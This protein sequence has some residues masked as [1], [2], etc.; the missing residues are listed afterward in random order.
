MAKTEQK[1]E[2][3]AHK[4]SHKSLKKSL[5]P[6]IMFIGVALV[7]AVG[8]IAGTYNNQIM[9]ALGP[10]F[11][12]HAHA[13]E[14]DLSSVQ[15]TYRALAAN[16][17]GK[18]D[19]MAL[20]QGANHGLVAA[21]GDQYTV[22]MSPEEATA[23]D[24]G[25]AGNIGGGIGAEIG[26]RNDQVTIIRTLSGNPAE[27][28]GL[29]AGDIILKINDES[30]SGWTVEKAVG[31]IRGE[32]GT[33]VKLTIERGSDIHDYTI[34]RAIITNPSV[35]SSVSGKVGTLTI[36]RFDNETGTL[37]RA[38]AQS[39]VKQG[40]KDVILDLRGNGGGYLVAA[41]DVASLWLNNQIV[42]TEQTGGKVVD[43]VKSG[44]NAVLAGMPTVVLVNASTASASE[45][46]AGALQD[47]GVAKLVGEKTY[48]KG[49]VQKPLELPGG[50]MLKVTVARWY[51]PNGISVTKNGITPNYVVSLTQEDVNAGRDPQ[52]D[53]AM[54]ILGL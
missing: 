13:G 52:V 28:V 31:L 8:Y 32:E 14:I 53:Q 25:L 5:S 7:A 35:T 9:A 42:V 29:S 2:P 46:L 50:A 41:K 20:I 37:A 17:D 45:I 4:H 11:G 30:T 6:A 3:G 39:F 51:T 26:L 33:T 48:G 21:A 15:D 22:Y 34:T 38:A 16:F 12:Y 40:I 43:T 18:L 19:T 27:K 47:H 10:I 24:D 49:S 1:S 36:S 44:N 23:F 54:K